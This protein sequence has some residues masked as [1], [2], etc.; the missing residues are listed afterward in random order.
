MGGSGVPAAPAA[1]RFSIG[2]LP[3]GPIYS[4]AAAP[5]NGPRGSQKSDPSAAVPAPTRLHGR[6]SATC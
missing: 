2:F 5:S 4:L 3:L 1:D 6:F